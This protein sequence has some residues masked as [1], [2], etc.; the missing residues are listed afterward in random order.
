MANVAKIL[1]IEADDDLCGKLITAL[2]NEGFKPQAA[3]NRAQAAALL[4]S[5]R[6]DAIVSEV[7]LPDGDVEQICRDAHRFIGST[8]IVFTNASADVDQ[9]IRL[10]KNGAVD[11]LQKPYHVPGLVARLR[12]ITSE[13]PSRTDQGTWPDPIMVS[14]AMLELKRRLERLAASSVSTLIVGEPGSG[15][16]VIARYI[17]RL[18]AR[19]NEPFIALRCGSFAGPDGERI[20]FGEV[21]R[22]GIDT[23]EVHSGGLEQAGHGAVFL[24]E[25]SELPTAVQGKLIQAIDSKRFMRVGD[26][27][28]ELR[29]EARI[30]ASSQFS[31]AKLRER[32]SADLVNRI[33]VIEIAVP[34]LRERQ[35][36]IEPL[37]KALLMD[38]AS[39]LGVPTLLVEA[40]ALAAMRAHDW[41]AN[42]RELRNRL[43]RALS[44]A[45]GGK[46]GVADVFPDGVVVR[47]APPS[48]STLNGARVAAERQRI[49]EALTRHQGRVGRAAESLG[50]SRVTLWTKM[51]RFGLSHQSFPDNKETL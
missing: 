10:L 2:A 48:K 38:V 11:Y 30:L 45:N 31:A 51:K 15:K 49:V 34:P 28:T 43:V 16:E 20:L 50:I 29:F 32:L 42:V 5:L 40:E 46:I 19:A 47:T 7:R 3:K 1:L 26:L 9:I 37:V 6:F 41:P 44:F 21:L 24:D 25:I 36:D 27:G 17:Q 18:S 33:P 22:S 12:R 23:E 4:R 8:P 13:Q 35:A 39:E 14:P